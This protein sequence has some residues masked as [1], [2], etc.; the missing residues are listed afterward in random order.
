VGD[1]VVQVGGL[2]AFVH[3]R[4]EPLNLCLPLGAYLLYRAAAIVDA[5][6][7]ARRAA[8]FRWRW[9][10]RWPIYAALVV[11]CLYVGDL[12]IALLLRAHVVEAFWVRTTSMSDTILPGDRF[13]VDKLFYS[14]PARLD[15]VAYEWTDTD[16]NERVFIHRIVA[17]PGE[18]FEIRENKV[19]IDSRELEEPYVRLDGEPQRDFGP[20]VV[21]PDSY[22]VLGD[23]RNVS[24][25][26]RFP[27]IGCVPRDRIVGPAMTITDSTD[28]ESGD[29]RWDRIGQVIR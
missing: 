24:K 28:L 17:L 23:R 6:R 11:S 2:L 14:E 25:D 13:L 10:I 19:F 12:Q 7:V 3:L 27:E 18:R 22:F 1:V 8:Q 16:G 15:V 5:V 21:P 29:M 26:S 4:T 20:T 9:F